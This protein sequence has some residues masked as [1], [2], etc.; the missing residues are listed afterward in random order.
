MPKTLVWK[1]IAI[2]KPGMNSVLVF[3]VAHDLFQVTPKDSK[4]FFMQ[5]MILPQIMNAN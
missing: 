1:L 5:P 4:P 3:C 2:F